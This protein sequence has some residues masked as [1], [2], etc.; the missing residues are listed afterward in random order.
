MED[1]AHAVILSRGAGLS[2]HHLA[3]RLT[4]RQAREV[5][6]LPGGRGPEAV[7]SRVG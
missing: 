7:L 5:R 2:E 1:R 3:H 6:P 4:A